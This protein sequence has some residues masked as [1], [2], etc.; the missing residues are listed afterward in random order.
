VTG[1]PTYPPVLFVYQ[2]TV[3]DGEAFFGAFWPEAR[4][5]SDPSKQLYQAFG[6][7]QGSL[8]QLT[9]PGVW[10]CAIRATVQGN[11]VGKPVGDP[12]QMPGVFL[13][14][15]AEILWHHD[16]AHA[17]DNPDWTKV[18]QLRDVTLVLA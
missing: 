11:T 17:G 4:A 7:H 6:L 1:D 2:G 12:W 14:Q 5:V 10:A 16:Y 15:G 9:S 3:A 13:V 8:R 18:P